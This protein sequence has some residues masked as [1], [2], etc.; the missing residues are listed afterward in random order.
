MPMED[1]K[2]LLSHIQTREI[3]G[4]IHDGFRFKRY[5]HQSDLRDAVYADLSPADGTYCTS[6]AG[7][8]CLQWSGKRQNTLTENVE[9]RRR[10]PIPAANP[11]NTM[12]VPQPTTT[13]LPEPAMAT[14]HETNIFINQETMGRLT[15][16]GIPTSIP[17][18]GPS[19][20]QPMY[21]MPQAEAGF[22]L[23]ANIDL[24]LLGISPY[25]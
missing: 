8:N 13:T 25:P 9:G 7:G 16:L 12:F 22:S 10:C 15:A 18:N 14:A 5:W 23:P 19:D 17:I 11:Q 21:H 6:S 4:G 20:G 24:A 1:I 2:T 3:S